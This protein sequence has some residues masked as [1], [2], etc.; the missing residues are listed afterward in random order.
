[1][2]KISKE[3]V[4]HNIPLISENG[5]LIILLERIYLT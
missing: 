1:M 4:P 3:S 5:L 2:E